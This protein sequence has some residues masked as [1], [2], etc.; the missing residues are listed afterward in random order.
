M[1]A[2]EDKTIVVDDVEG[3]VDVA[4]DGVTS[5]VIPEMMMKISEVV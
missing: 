5:V 1:D 4:E 2:V 3:V